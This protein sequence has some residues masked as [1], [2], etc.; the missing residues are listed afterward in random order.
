MGMGHEGYGL[1]VHSFRRFFGS[2]LILFSHF[3]GMLDSPKSEF[4]DDGNGIEV[5]AYITHR[6][7]L[8]VGGKAWL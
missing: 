1:S 3:P 8:V 7:L 2:F 6:L 5:T 4:L